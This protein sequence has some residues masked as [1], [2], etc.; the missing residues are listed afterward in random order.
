VKP[1]ARLP[2][3]AAPWFG[4]FQQLSIRK[5]L[6]TMVLLPLAVVLPLLG[7]I[8]LAWSTVAFDRLLVT[9][10]RSDLAV[11]QSYFRQLLNDVGASAAAIAGSHALHLAMTQGSQPD[12]VS[13]LQRATTEQTVDFINLRRPDGTALLSDVGLAIAGEPASQAWGPAAGARVR[14]TIEVLDHDELVRTAP[15][16]LPRVAVP[17]VATRNALPTERTVEDRAMLAMALAP[18]LGEQGELLGYVQTGV[19]LNR[20]LPFIDYINS[21]VY[22]EGSLPFGSRGT[23]T[24]FLDDVRI[25]TNV[26]L[27][28]DDPNHRAIGT[29]VSRAVRSEVFER[30]GTWL[31]RAFVV[32]DWYV[33]AYEPLTDGSGQRVGMLYVGFLERPFLWVKYG[34]LAGIA[35]VFLVVTIGAAVVSLRWARTIFAPVERMASTIARVE[36]GDLASRV[37]PLQ[38]T[39]ELGRLAMHLDRLLDTIDDK[40]QAL[41]EANSVLDAKVVARTAALEAAQEQ[42]VQA[43]RLAAIGQLT[44]SVAHE[45]N[46]PMAVIQGNLDLARE[47]IGP[48]SARA[49]SEFRLIDAQIERVRLIATQL[50]QLARPGEF[51]GYLEA[52]DCAQVFDECLRLTEHLRR[53]Q[54]IEVRRDYRSRRQ[55]TVNRHELQQ[56]LVNLLSNAIHVMPYGGELIASVVDVGPD[57]VALQVADSGP[58][59]EPGGVEELFKP[60]VTRRKDG[61]GLG[62][63]ICLNIVERHGGTIEAGNR[64]DGQRG[65]VFAVVLEGVETR[66]VSGRPEDPLPSPPP[67]EPAVRS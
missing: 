67:R 16:L 56:V 6:L 44:A 25:A 58:G 19:L 21:V 52:V 55:P 28:G 35:L 1:G 62:L 7:I 39:D 60:F 53:G 18:I 14:A 31:G 22:P 57:R 51:A 64:S 3:A 32:S 47:L 41:Q 34:T 17:L 20:N 43:E 36:A 12:L 9:K 33:S 61:T 24:L 27:F 15:R 40:T 54:A 29:R 30:G 38:S 5:K 42:V 45:I 8:L 2:G 50:L 4:R 11:A 10:A 23:A 49:G 66:E 65:A 13:L 37:G 26:R 63:W 46:N 48:H 59:L